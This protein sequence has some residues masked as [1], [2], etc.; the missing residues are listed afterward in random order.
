MYYINKYCAQIKK[1]FLGTR[2]DGIKVKVIV[3]LLLVNKY[4]FDQLDNDSIIE[5]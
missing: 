4:A 3:L 5:L 1:Q 2:S